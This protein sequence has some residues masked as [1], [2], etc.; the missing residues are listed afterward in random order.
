MAKAALLK[1]QTR[2]ISQDFLVG[3]ARLILYADFQKF[4]QTSTAF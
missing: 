2:A 4:K 1:E 3:V